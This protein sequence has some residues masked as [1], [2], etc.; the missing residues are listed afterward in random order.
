MG[1]I[2]AFLLSTRVRKHKA[3]RNSS[4]LQQ[5]MNGFMAEFRDANA[6]V[7]WNA[8]G[9]YDGKNNN[10]MIIGAQ[11]TNLLT[12]TMATATVDLLQMENSWHSR[13]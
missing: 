7:I 11:H 2:T 3:L 1:V 6:R 5:K 9:E 12:I 4:S 10:K 8:N 13:G